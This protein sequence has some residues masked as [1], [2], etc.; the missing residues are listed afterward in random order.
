MFTI[1]RHDRNWNSM[2]IAAKKWYPTF[3]Y[4][5]YF[6]RGGNFK[7]HFILM[8]VDMD[9]IGT[10]GSEWSSLKTMETIFFSLLDLFSLG[11]YQK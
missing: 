8:N 3:A 6:L 7:I 11:Q 9:E 2:F 10:S 1:L 5:S 4:C